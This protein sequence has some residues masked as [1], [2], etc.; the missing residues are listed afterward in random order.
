[1]IEPLLAALTGFLLGSL[2]TGYLLVA[3]AGRGDV[4]RVGSGN[5]GATNVGRV[6]G[7]AGWTVTLIIDGAKGAAA[8]LVASYVW[9]P[10][11]SIMAAAG[12]AAIL[13]HCF[14]PWLGFQGGKG[15]ATMLGTFLVLAPLAVL[16]VLVVFAA[17]AA[18]LRMVSAA[19]LA[20]SVALPV[21]AW[22]LAAPIPVVLAAA[23]TTLLVIYRH[24]ANLARILAGSEARI[25][26]R[27][28]SS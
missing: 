20:A 11:P 10:V 21:A 4:R 24:R 28:K 26:Q 1:M 17:L 22:L 9:G 14:T 2:P 13:G 16:A 3:A 27:E 23:A 25:G 8:V 19:S 12:F 6:L 7:P 5:I 18:S 15:V